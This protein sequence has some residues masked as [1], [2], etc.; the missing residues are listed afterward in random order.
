MS[1]A[2]VERPS[3][4]QTVATLQG[5]AWPDWV[6]QDVR[7]Y[8][9]HVSQGIPLRVLARDLGCHASTVMRQ[10]RKCESRR[11]DPLFDAALGWCDR[12]LTRASEPPRPFE[13]PRQKDP[14]MI[15]SLP[16]LPNHAQTE[17]ALL[18]ATRAAL[19]LLRQQ[20]TKL[21][22]APDLPKAV[23]LRDTPDGGG[24]K[25]AI[26][27]RQQAEALALRGWIRLQRSGRVSTYTLAPQGE[28]VLTIRQADPSQDA[29]PDDMRRQRYSQPETP[30]AMLARRRDRQG[31]AFLEPALVRVAAH[32]H[33]DFILA[34]LGANA[35]RDPSALSDMLL[36]APAAGP[37]QRAA[38][39]RLHAI[40]QHLG[41]GLS[42]IA[43]RCCCHQD[44]I[45]AAE[46][47]LDWSARSGKIV[48]R[49]ALQR[50][51]QALAEQGSAQCLIS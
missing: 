34:S 33:E 19:M 3:P 36:D 43:L 37:R 12:F 2:C 10:V 5:D 18:A 42:D 13:S 35:P 38:R 40:L 31:T 8:L 9:A 20:D 4:H 47:D 16:A 15:H 41:P 23:V 49:I 7:L 48:L 30:I 50:A 6:P 1:L 46:R 45:E 39:E 26:L 22:V 32:L 24:E 21:V 27:D 28:A 11:D 29:D 44:G 17:A 51:A 14:K 25:L